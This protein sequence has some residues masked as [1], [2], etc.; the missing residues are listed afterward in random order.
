MGTIKTIGKSGLDNYND[1]VKKMGNYQGK[2][3]KEMGRLY[4]N[5]KDLNDAIVT[6]K[7][8]EF[9]FGVSA[10]LKKED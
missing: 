8:V 3:K 7:N 6:Y 9:G 1:F 10:A 5:N 4:Q 2:S